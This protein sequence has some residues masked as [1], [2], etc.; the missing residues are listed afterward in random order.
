MDCLFINLEGSFRISKQ[1]L[2]SDINSYSDWEVLSLL[3]LYNKK[4]NNLIFYKFI[5]FY[6]I[7]KYFINLVNYFCNF[8]LSISKFYI[9]F[10]YFIGFLVNNNKNNIIFVKLNIFYNLKFMNNI[11]NR[12]INNYYSMDFFLKNSKI[13]SFSSLYKNRIF[14]L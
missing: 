6:K 3:N 1:V 12:F 14:K 7:T 8:F 2:K 4:N 10:F 5:K 11:F 13:M 9:E